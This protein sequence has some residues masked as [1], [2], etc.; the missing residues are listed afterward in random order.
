M[1]TPAERVSLDVTIA[2][3]S[4]T[5]TNARMPAK[6]GEPIVM[7]VSSDAAD[8]LHVHSVPPRTFDVKPGNGQT[9]EFTVDVPG[10]VDVELHDL[11]R[12]VVT[13]EVRP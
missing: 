1:S 6:V 13:F 9:F 12:V 7:R 2:A 11:N 4:V 3:G 5:P 8:T 10:R